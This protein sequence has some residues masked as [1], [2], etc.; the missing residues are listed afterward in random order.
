MKVAIVGSRSLKVDIDK[1]IPENTEVI[2]S[3]GAKG[4]DTIAEKFADD[5]GLEKCII[6]PDYKRYKRGA[7]L[8]RNKEI[9]EK[10][11]LILAFWDGKSR[12][13]MHTVKYAQECGKPVRVYTFE[14]E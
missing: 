5:H 6:K 13:T 11:D 3:G 9:V 7:P 14:S 4:I 12:G 1:Y 2:I 8:R 10:A